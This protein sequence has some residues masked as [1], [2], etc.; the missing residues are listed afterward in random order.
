MSLFE[1]ISLFENTKKLIDSWKPKKQNQKELEYSDDCYHLLKEKLPKSQVTRDDKNN[2]KGLD[3]GLREETM[4]GVE[5]VGIEF[6]L[7]LKSTSECTRLIGQIETK[8][9]QYKD[10]IIVLVGESNNNMVVE[11]ENWINGKKDKFTGYS[12]KRCVIKLKG[13]LN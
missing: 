2:K 3:I 4:Y 13:K 6:K 12:A 5:S 1:N 11:L 9:K 10:I 8:G 7:N